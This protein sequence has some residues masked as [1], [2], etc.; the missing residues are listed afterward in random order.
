MMQ[1]QPRGGT[2]S[3]SEG[4][5]PP[6]DRWSDRGRVRK[7]GEKT[8]VPA[9]TYDDVLLIEEYSQEEPGALQLKYYA[10]GVGNVRVGWESKDPMKESL[11]LVRVVQLGPEEMDQVR[12]EAFGI[13]ERAYA[14]G[15]TPPAQRRTQ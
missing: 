9:G 11:E 14:Y 12:A 7:V 15:S 10:P 5:G 3:Y 1:A 8:T 4:F 13:E 6:P 2:P